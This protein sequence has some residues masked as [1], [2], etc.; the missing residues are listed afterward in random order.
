MPLGASRSL[1]GGV[2]LIM[3]ALVVVGLANGT[4]WLVVA[5]I[6]GAIPT[7]ALKDYAQFGGASLPLVAWELGEAPHAV[8]PAWNVGGEHDLMGPAGTDPIWS[9]EMWRLS[10]RGHQ[11]CNAPNAH[12]GLAGRL[13]EH[14][15]TRRVTG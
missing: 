5:G 1:A 10:E 7:V 11:A 9:E 6:V 4:G 8:A 12:A 3:L 13:A 14:I 15:S 2:L